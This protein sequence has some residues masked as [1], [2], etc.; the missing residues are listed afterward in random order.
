MVANHGRQTPS[1]S[2]SGHSDRGDGSGAGE[3]SGSNIEN[4]LAGVGAQFWG[5]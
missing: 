2:A 1:P 4:D 3:E 5:S